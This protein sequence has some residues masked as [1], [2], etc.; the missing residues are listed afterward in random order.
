[1]TRH[2][3]KY[4]STESGRGQTGP[5]VLAGDKINHAGKY[6]QTRPVGETEWPDQMRCVNIRPCCRARP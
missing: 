2:S 1:M 3:R 5:T 4:E 6:G